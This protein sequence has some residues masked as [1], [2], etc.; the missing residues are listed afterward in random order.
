V[1][2]ATATNTRMTNRP[3]SRTGSFYEFAPDRV[4]VTKGAA[5]F[6]FPGTLCSKSEQLAER[7]ENAR[8]IMRRQTASLCALGR[9]RI[10]QLDKVSGA[11]IWTAWLM[12]MRQPVP[13]ARAVAM[14]LV[15]VVAPKAPSLAVLRPAR[16]DLF[17]V[18]SR[19]F[20]HGLPFLQAIE[21][22]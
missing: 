21:Q 14:P 16:L 2:I 22:V 20:T 10:F 15:A 9:Y 7:R 1:K 5:F 13:S 3:S 11:L 12:A 4:D 18:N 17:A 8:V 19:Y 6:V